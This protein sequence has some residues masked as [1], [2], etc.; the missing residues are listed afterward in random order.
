MSLL[1]MFAVICLDYRTVVNV[2]L[3]GN[4]FNKVIDERD[5]APNTLLR[6]IQGANKQTVVSD[7]MKVSVRPI[8]A[9]R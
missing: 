3:A 4:T 6:C 2:L 5:K 9:I 7:L 1:A 8:F